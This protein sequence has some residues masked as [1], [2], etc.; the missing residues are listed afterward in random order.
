MLSYGIE[1]LCI[2][3]IVA[4]GNVHFNKFGEQVLNMRITKL[5]DALLTIWL[6]L[7]D[8]DA[9]GK[10]ASNQNSAVLDAAALEGSELLC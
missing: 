2:N 8:R 7:R 4:A 3:L 9:N 1:I 10:E 6:L 5:Y